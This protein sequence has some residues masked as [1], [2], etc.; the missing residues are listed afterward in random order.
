MNALSHGGR[1]GAP[2]SRRTVQYHYTILSKSLSDAVRMGL[3]AVNPCKAV[4]RPRVQRR[5]VPSLSARD[6]SKLVFAL[7]QSQYGVF[8]LTLLFS[9]LRRGEALALRW[10]DIS[11]DFSCIFVNR[12]LARLRDGT[13]LYKE[14]K[15][16]KGC[17]V[18]L[19]LFLSE[20]LRQ[21]RAQEEEKKA[22]VGSELKDTDLVFSNLD[23]TPL[24]TSTLV[25]AFASVVSKAQVPRIRLHDLR[26]LNASMLLQIG[27]PDKVVAERLG[28]SS[29]A[30]TLDVYGHLLPTIQ[31][32][33]AARLQ[34]IMSPKML[35][36]LVN[37]QERENVGNLSAKPDESAWWGR[38]DSNP[39]ALRHMIL[40]HARLPVPALPQV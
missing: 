36:L 24:S 5:K 1:N 26:H 39:H 20:L 8:Y 35:K 31:K 13:Y 16:G 33:A 29:A 2:L 30:F 28:H 3:L 11:P 34:E 32:L 12:S 9:G 18:E 37:P 7:R 38:G 27:I 21:H 4:N 17:A 14:P 10:C 25:H 23:G 22:F 6:I 15:T 19:P 40:S